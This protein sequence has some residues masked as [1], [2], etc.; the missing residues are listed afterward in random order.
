[1]I[2]DHALARLASLPGTALA[3]ALHVYLPRKVE[4]LVNGVGVPVY[5]LEGRVTDLVSCTLAQRTVCGLV[6][7]S[8]LAVTSR[9]PS[10][11][12]QS[13]RSRFGSSDHSRDRRVH[14]SLS[15]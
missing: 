12:V 1:M 9:S 8:A 5:G 4:F 2:I 11:R 13:R 7:E 10:A 3:H 15:E 6:D 14:V